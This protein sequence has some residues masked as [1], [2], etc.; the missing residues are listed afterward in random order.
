MLL[1]LQPVY[2]W[3]YIF[4]CLTFLNDEHRL[5]SPAGIDSYFLMPHFGPDE[6]DLK[7]CN[8]SVDVG[9]VCHSP[10]EDKLRCA[11]KVTRF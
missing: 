8:M 9:L 3:S 5:L 2:L 1:W 10:K 6:G 11:Q 4:F 7:Q